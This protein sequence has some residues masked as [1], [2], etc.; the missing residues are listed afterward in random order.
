MLSTFLSV[1]FPVL[2]AAGMGWFFG[3]WWKGRQYED[4]TE[5]YDEMRSKSRG[6]DTRNLLTKNDLD[7]RFASLSSSFASAPKTDLGPLNRRLSS[8]ETA[9]N[10]INMPETNLTPIYE[11]LT[12]IDQRLAQPQGNSEDVTKRIAHLQESVNEVSRRVANLQN[13]DLDPLQVRFNRLESTISS[14]ETG[15]TDIDLE[16]LQSSVSMLELALAEMELPETDLSPIQE[17][18]TGLEL[19]VVD[20]ADRVENARGQDFETINSELVRMSSSFS[21]MAMPDL[22]PV[23]QRLFGVE[24]AVANLN[25]PETDLTPLFLR[26]EQIEERLG[27]PGQLYQNLYARLERLEQ[28]LN[29][30][31]QE[32][33]TLYGRLA[34]MEAAIDALDRGPVD[35]SPLHNRI[36]ALENIIATMRNDLQGIPSLEPIERQLESLLHSVRSIPQPDLSSV[37][38]QLS[39]LQQSIMSIPQTDLSPVVSSMRSIDSR[40][41]MAAMENR[42]TAIEYGLTAV[43]HMLRSR[44]DAPAP[45]SNIEPELYASNASP[46]TKSRSS[47]S[48]TT[49]TSNAP[50]TKS[51]YTSSTSYSSRSS[52]SGND[53]IESVRRDDRSNLL[54]SA[55]FGKPDDL[56]RISGIGPM[57]SDMLQDIGVYYFWQIA[58]WDQSDIVWVDGKLEHFNGRIDR[59]NW[60][61][62]AR[63]FSAESNAAKRPT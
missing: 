52:R 45:I 35:L 40:L 16:P 22:D 42:L 7:D 61:G 57:L 8:I 49:T 31:D 20:L 2:L 37:D 18:L 56:E 43:H 34:G 50:S 12:R 48:Y 30:P 4:V 5:T 47:S 55:S 15:G 10:G 54:R 6:L 21:T 63:Q 13:T 23:E 58:E 33:Q 44:Q 41:D 32:F 17:Q 1:L 59:D 24:R 36:A 27:E 9:V 29:E 25:V 26:L 62:Q 53:P 38:R 11:R 51:S 3:W 14:L 46:T 39:S 28:V 60:V 19:R